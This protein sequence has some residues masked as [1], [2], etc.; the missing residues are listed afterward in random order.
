M[1]CVVEVRCIFS[2]VLGRGMLAVPQP[3]DGLVEGAAMVVPEPRGGMGMV[4]RQGESAGR[5]R[6]GRF[7]RWSTRWSAVSRTERLA[8]FVL[9]IPEG[10]KSGGEGG[11]DGDGAG[12]FADRGG[13]WSLG[14]VEVAPASTPCVGVLRVEVVDLYLLMAEAVSHPTL[15]R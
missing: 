2:R 8:P 12:G 7:G 10:D 6:P 4:N 15:L 9:D 3:E 1:G 11:G 13:G 5:W 14:G